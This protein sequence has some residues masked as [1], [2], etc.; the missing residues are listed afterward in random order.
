ME[1]FDSLI[2]LLISEVK[3]KSK[4]VKSKNKGERVGKDLRGE[5]RRG[6]IMARWRNC[7]RSGGRAPSMKAK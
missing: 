4:K 2:V 3:K 7:K 1:V 6:G 5:G